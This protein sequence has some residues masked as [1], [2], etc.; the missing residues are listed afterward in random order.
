MDACVTAREA[1]AAVESTTPQQRAQ[2]PASAAATSLRALL[3]VSGSV[4]L[5]LFS[6]TDV[7]V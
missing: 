1:R 4:S 7:V 3:S 5:A 2:A 6:T